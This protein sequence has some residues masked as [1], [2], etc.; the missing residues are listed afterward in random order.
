MLL[1][2]KCTES[3]YGQCAVTGTCTC[4]MGLD[5]PGT[6]MILEPN[7]ASPCTVNVL[8]TGYA[9]MVNLSIVKFRIQT[10]ESSFFR[11]T[12]HN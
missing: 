2:A 5:V 9:R 8:Y 10:K 4:G 6:S 7:V 11:Y 3:M 12:F 1:E